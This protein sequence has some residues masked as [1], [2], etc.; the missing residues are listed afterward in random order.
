MQLVTKLALSSFLSRL[1]NKVFWTNETRYA[2]N[3]PKALSLFGQTTPT[4]PNFH[5]SD[6]PRTYHHSH[7]KR[8]RRSEA[9]MVRGSIKMNAIMQVVDSWELI[10][11]KDSDWSENFGVLVF[12]K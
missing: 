2:E 12:E 8:N 11:R 3:V 5:S 10:K 4:N 6:S 9:T 1:P 7:N